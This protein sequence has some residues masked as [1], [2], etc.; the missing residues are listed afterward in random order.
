MAEFFRVVEL[1]MVF[2]EMTSFD[3]MGIECV[4][5][6]EALGRILADNVIATEDMPPWPRATMDGYAVRA[7][8]T[9]GSSDATPTL[10]TVVGKVEMGLF[11]TCEIAHGEACYIPTGGFLPKGADAV[12]MIEYVGQVGD[13]AIEVNRPVTTGENV[14]DTGWDVARNEVVLRRGRRLRPQDLGLLAGLGIGSVRVFKRPKV[15]L[16]STG[17][18]V[19]PLDQLPRLGQVRDMNRYS[20]GA[21]VKAAGGQIVGF[22]LVPDTVEALRTVLQQGL[23]QADVVVLSGGS[24]VGERDVV[25]EVVKGFDSAEV[26]VHGI[27][28]R[29]GK[30]TLLARINGKAV[31][32]LP[33]HPVSALMVGYVFLVP[34]LRFLH[35][36]DEVP[37][38]GPHGEKKEAILTTSIASAPGQQEYV[39]V[40]VEDRQGVLYARPMFGKSSMISTMVKSDGV[41]VVPLCAEGLAQG[42]KVEVILF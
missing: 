30:P 6:E 37:V 23:Q 28:M 31:V 33:G 39:R 4:C 19:V 5:I 3:R 36:E 13:T 26:L 1:S 38:P 21:L 40:C 34:F 14:L 20:L 7:S 24:S 16:V 18:E 29:P 32:G 22:R 25:V 2:S 9:F 15:F 35:G 42:T 8:D 17:D 12:V 27:A 10:L 41:I 11:P